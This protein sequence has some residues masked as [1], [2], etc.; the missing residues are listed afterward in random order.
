MGMAKKMMDEWLQHRVVLEKI[1]QLIPDKDID[2]S[3]WMVQCLSASS[4]SIWRDQQRCLLRSPSLEKEKSVNRMWLSAKRLKSCCKS[5]K[6]ARNE[7]RV[8]L[9][10]LPMRS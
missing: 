3:P 7:R 10:R 8:Y 2:F 5:Y 1:I 9:R 4:L 6:I